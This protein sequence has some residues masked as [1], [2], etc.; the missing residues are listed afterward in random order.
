[1]RTANA[2]GKQLY[3][4]NRFKTLCESRNS[5]LFQINQNHAAHQLPQA[6]Q[7]EANEK[8]C[9]SPRSANSLKMLMTFSA[10]RESRPVV[11]SSAN[12]TDGLVIISVAI[13]KRFFSP[14]L[15][16][17]RSQ[18]ACAGNS[19]PQ[20][21]YT[22]VGCKTT[23]CTTPAKIHKICIERRPLRCHLEVPYS[24]VLDFRQ[25][26][27]FHQTVNQLRPLFLLLSSPQSCLSE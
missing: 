22:E 27:Q 18:Q 3:P 25:A 24:R 13:F 26:V 15:I 16:P 2:P 6:T 8:L 14:P 10:M 23:Q 7:G 12:I 17:L 19:T 1:M 5:S 4:K 9:S 11:G 21:F 20:P